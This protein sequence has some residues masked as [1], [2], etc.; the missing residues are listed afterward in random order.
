M[1]KKLTIAVDERVCEGLH[2]I[3]GTGKIG[4]FIERLVRSRILYRHLRAGYKEM[5][6][7]NEREGAASEW[8]EALISDVDA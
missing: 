4:R 5:A 3:V 1:R 8:S 6:R 2:T 7:D